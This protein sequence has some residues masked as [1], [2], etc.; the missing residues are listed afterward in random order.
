M[1]GNDEP[2]D[3]KALAELLPFYA[4]GTLDSSGRNRVELG[5]Q[6]SAWLR[7]E[8]EAEQRLASRIKAEGEKMTQGGDMSAERLNALMEKIDGEAPGTAPAP[9]HVAQ[10]P[11]SPSEVRSLMSYLNPK[12]WHPAMALSLAFAV[13][14]QAA[15]IGGQSATIASLEKENFELASG[16]GQARKGAILLEV[17]DEALW[18]D[19]TA[20]LDV[21][22]LTIVES[23]GFGALTLASEKKGPELS[24][25][26][27]RLRKSPLIVSAEP[28]A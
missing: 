25:Q 21:E 13:A 16:P 14:V 17:K 10:T 26:I 19:V 12:R 27:E 3:I 18:K 15:V 8:F 7:D 6:R 28:A 2:E 1:S 9:Q 22:G 23:G 24:A 20:L 11:A 5:L 4:N